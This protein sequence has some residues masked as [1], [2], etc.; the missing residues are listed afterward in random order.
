MRIVSRLNLIASTT[1]WT[2]FVLLLL[3]SWILLFAVPAQSATYYVDS[4]GGNDNDNGTSTST[5]WQTIAKVNSS[6]FS[7][8]DQILFKSGDIWREQ[9]NISS[10]GVAASPV[11]F[12]FYGSGSPPVISGADLAVGWASSTNGNVTAWFV[13]G[14]ATNQVFEDGT[15]L[16]SSTALGT[17]QA[18]SFY[19][20]GSDNVYV[21]TLAGDNP[22]NHTMEISH[23]NYAVYEAGGSHYVTL[24]GL[25]TDK[26]NGDDI[27]FNGSSFVTVSQTL[28]TNAFNEGLRFDAVASSIINSS[29]SAYNGSNGLAADDSPNLVINGCIAHD[30]AALANV[31]FTAGIKINPDYSPFTS[32][33]NVTIENSESYHNGVGQPDWRGAGI[34]ADTIGNNLLI[35]YNLVYGNNTQGIYFDAV[36]N[37]TAAYN[38]VFGNGQNGAIDGTGIAVY[39]DGR[40][41]VGDS[42]FGNTV[43]GSLLTGINV[44]GANLSQGCSAMIVNNNIVTGT[45]AGPNFSATGGCEN[46][47]LDG[48]GNVYTRN[49]FG[50]ESSNFIQYGTNNYLSKYAAFDAAYGASTGSVP[51]DPSF[52]NPNGNDFTLQS[53]SPAIGTGLNLGPSFEMALAP[54]AVWPSNVATTGQNN[55]GGG[56]DLGAYVHGPSTTSA[57]AAP[58]NLH[59]TMQ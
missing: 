40:T 20:D 38:V 27:Y 48:S 17:M 22:N 3:G 31:D 24:Q 34:W 58:K 52:S 7:P 16:A 57:P 43:S 2:S 33:T 23:R 9:L 12:G 53:S 55:S 21:Q 26:A 59:A 11:V 39:G 8:G 46:P 14:N 1:R 47:G 4:A 49:A 19:W 10:S 28:I 29:I 42:V 51:G 44:S 50:P 35:E 5:P 54:S 37:A 6:K 15:R 56:W 18:G 25:Q 41:V 45:T 32:S 13:R 36:S 30:N